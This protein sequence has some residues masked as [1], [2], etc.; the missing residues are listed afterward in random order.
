MRPTLFAI[1][2]LLSACVSQATP[3]LPDAGVDVRFASHTTLGSPDVPPIRLLVVGG[4]SNAFGLGRL[5][6]LTNRA[7][8]A[9]PYPAIIQTQRLSALADPIPWVDITSRP[10]QP[11]QTAEAGVVVNTFGP[12]LSMGHALSGSWT[13]GKIAINGSGLDINWRPNAAWPTL[14]IGESELFEQFDTFIT[15]QEFSA[16]VP[17]SVLVWVQGEHDAKNATQAGRYAENLGALVDT[18]RARH[19]D[20]L[21]V[22]NRLD[23]Q[24]QIVGAGKQIVRDQQMLYATTATRTVMVS[25]DDLSL[26]DGLHFTTD[27]YVTLGERFADAINTEAP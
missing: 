21:F 14:P 12:E 10:L 20:F 9:V 8:L 7:D 22:F 18:L 24:A 1:C 25:C 4:Q 2:A 6:E 26:R 3:D 23:D 15:A 27:S 16:G 17:I 19:G 11:R 5:G 13:F